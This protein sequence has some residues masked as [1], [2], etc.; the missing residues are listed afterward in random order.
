[1]SAKEPCV[2]AKEPYIS[3]EEPCVSAKE[4]YTFTKKKEPNIFYQTM[5]KFFQQSPS[6]STH[7]RDSADDMKMKQTATQQ[8]T[9]TTYGNTHCNS[10]RQHHAT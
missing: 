5:P 9:A 10:T 1:M 6:F 2:F 8:H 3:A 7:R 4:P